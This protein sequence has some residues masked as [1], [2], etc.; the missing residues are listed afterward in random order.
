MQAAQ[1]IPDQPSTAIKTHGGLVDAAGL[2]DIGRSR[3]T[4]EDA[5]LIATLQRSL[6][7]HDASPVA[8]GWFA[9]EAAGTMLVV[10]DGMGG[11][12]GGDV[13]SRVAVNT[14]S[15]YLLNCMPWVTSAAVDDGRGSLPG[16]R[17]QLSSALVAGDSTVK[18][19]GVQSGAPHMGTTLTMALIVWPVLYVAHVGDTRC[20]LLRAGKLR[21]L[22]TDHTM[23]QQVAEASHQALDPTSHLHHI[24]WNALG[25]TEDL[26]KPEIKR[27]ELLPGDALVL[28][29]DGLTKHV[30][31]EEIAGTLA[32]VSTPAACCQRLVAR[33]NAEGGTDNVTVVIGRVSGPSNGRETQ[34]SA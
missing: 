34:P 23:A 5:Y 25:A 17:D 24:L 1:T 8:R 29:S 2:T 3:E 32:E 31:D 28:C 22:T 30:S 9:G 19:A 18:S 10:A 6:M 20:Y 12:G 27:L 15:S 33:A 13:A 21:C 4:N 7:V 16:V 14:V 26:P 11:Q